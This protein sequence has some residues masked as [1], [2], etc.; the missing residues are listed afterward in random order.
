MEAEFSDMASARRKRLGIVVGDS[1]TAP[2]TSS[3][4]SAAPVSSAPAPT[5]G[6]DEASPQRYV[7]ITKKP[8]YVPPSTAVDLEDLEDEPV[9]M[10]EE[11]PERSQNAALA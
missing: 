9:L 11:E 1:E 7:H 4:P 3:L 2:Q 6:G 8:L 5:P 10:D